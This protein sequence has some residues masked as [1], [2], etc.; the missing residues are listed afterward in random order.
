MQASRKEIDL[1]PRPGKLKTTV[2]APDKPQPPVAKRIDVTTSKMSFRHFSSDCDKSDSDGSLA[3]PDSDDEPDDEDDESRSARASVGR[4][5]A[6]NT[7]P[8]TSTIPEEDGPG[9]EMIDLDSSDVER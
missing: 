1:G 3:I 5:R 9:A 6:G 4:T 8:P 2:H 7:F